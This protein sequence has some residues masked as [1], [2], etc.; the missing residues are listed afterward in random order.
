MRKLGMKRRVR[1]RD[2]ER[3]KKDMCV[4]LCVWE[5]TLSFVINKS[6]NFP[7]SVAIV[8]MSTN[9]PRCDVYL[10]ICPRLSMH[11]CLLMKL[12]HTVCAC[13]VRRAGSAGTMGLIL[14]TIGVGSLQRGVLKKNICMA[15]RQWREWRRVKGGRRRKGRILGIVLCVLEST[16][17]QTSQSIK[18]AGHAY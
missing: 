18:Q 4:C 3:K 6:W 16:T 2:R 12:L 9:F 7:K 13:F 5:R 11:D 8:A 1:V 15:S 14:W 17:T 10:I